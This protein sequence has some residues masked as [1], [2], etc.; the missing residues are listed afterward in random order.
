[1]TTGPAT[2]GT[3]QT[4]LT[5]SQATDR[6]SHT[7]STTGPAT[8]VTT[9]TEL[10]TSQETDRTTQTEWTSQA[11]VGTSQAT[12]GTT[13]T[14]LTS[15]ATVETS[16][17][18]VETSQA[19]VGTTQTELTSQATD[20]TT[21]T[22]STAGPATLSTTSVELNATANVTNSQLPEATTAFSQSSTCIS[23]ANEI[24]L[25]KTFATLNEEDVV[26]LVKNITKSLKISKK[27]TNS[28]QRSL[29]S[30][31]DD[32]P[33]ARTLGHA[34]ILA[35]AIVIGGICAVDIPRFLRFAKKFSRW[36]DV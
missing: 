16:Q 35:I 24:C 17:A 6:T 30:V 13:Q 20:R 10:T 19:T 1:M 26:E 32:R 8:V 9:Q 11:T 33:S 22:V 27:K 3:T 7:V 18:T 28:Y 34:G 21:Y 25:C 15:Q 2:V 4:E 12:V 14:E 5:T 23:S 31:K 36:N 29:V